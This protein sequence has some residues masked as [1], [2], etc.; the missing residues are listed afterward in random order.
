M[1]R[2]IKEYANYKIHDYKDNELMRDEIKAEK[3]NQINKALTYAERG[4]ITVD[5]TINLI[6]EA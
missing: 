3:I 5:E 2:F 1:K 4:F 6:N